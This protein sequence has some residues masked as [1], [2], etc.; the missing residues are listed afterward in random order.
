MDW[1]KQFV[2]LP[3]SY[4]RFPI[5]IVQ[6]VADDFK[7]ADGL[8]DP[9]LVRGNEHDAFIYKIYRY[10]SV[11]QGEFKYVLEATG[12]LSVLQRFTAK[13]ITSH[14]A[15]QKQRVAAPPAEFCP[16]GVTAAFCDNV[17]HHPVEV[18]TALAIRDPD[19]PDC[20]PDASQHDYIRQL[21]ASELF[22]DTAHNLELALGVLALISGGALG[23]KHLQSSSVVI[24]PQS[25]EDPDLQIPSAAVRPIPVSSNWDA[26]KDLPLSQQQISTSPNTLRSQIDRNTFVVQVGTIGAY[27]TV[28]AIHLGDGLFVTV[29]HVFVDAAENARIIISRS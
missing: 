14:V 2:H 27:D 24:D 6:S 9:N 22:K 5:K 1:R 25:K 8:L 13:H 26:A 12:N 23:Y 18:P 19:I 28:H 10:K 16:C 7:G 20:L 21:L 29:A 3:A 17:D 4:R 11:A 15:H